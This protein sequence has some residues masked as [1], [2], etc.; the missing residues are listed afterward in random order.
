LAPLLL[1]ERAGAAVWVSLGLA[2]A[3]V[4]LVLQPSLQ[5]GNTAGLLRI[6]GAA[7]SA[8]AHMAIRRLSADDAPEVVVFGFLG[9]SAAAVAP[10]A[11]AMFVVPTPMEALGLVAVAVAGT[12]GQLLLTSAYA[13]ERAPAVSTA[14][15]A[16][17]LFSV[18]L[19]WALFGDLPSLPVWIGGALVVASGVLLLRSRAG[20]PPRAWAA[21]DRPAG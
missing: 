15:Y 9:L 14:S 2:L 5:V 8:G 16:S 11:V 21:P 13:V 19:G 12:A 20:A 4:V 1:S 3:G 18:A 7:C 6:A 10:F 17:T